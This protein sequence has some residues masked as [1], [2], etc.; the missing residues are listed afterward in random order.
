MGIRQT[1]QIHIDHYEGF[2]A[3]KYQTESLTIPARDGTN[4]PLVLSYNKDEYTDKSP[5]ILH[6]SGMSGS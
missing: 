4:I 1:S 5:F 3:N 6:A 2:D